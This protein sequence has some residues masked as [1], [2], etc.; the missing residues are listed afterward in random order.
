MEAVAVQ[1][2][3]LSFFSRRTRLPLSGLAEQV[4]TPLPTA[5][6]TARLRSHRKHYDVFIPSHDKQTAFV[7]ILNTGEN[8]AISNI[9]PTILTGFDFFSA[10]CLLMQIRS[11]KHFI[12]RILIDLK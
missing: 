7:N 12:E 2:A 10:V 11:L 3:G 9:L 5:V 1:F 6:P 4:G 8:N